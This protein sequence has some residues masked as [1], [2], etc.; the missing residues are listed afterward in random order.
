MKFDNFEVNISDENARLAA[1]SISWEGYIS[2]IKSKDPRKK[3]GFRMIP[4]IAIGNTNYNLLEKFQQLVPI[5]KLSNSGYRPNPKARDIWYWRLS[6]SFNKTIWFLKRIL[7]Y[8][9]SKQRQAE[10]LLEY[11]ISRC[12]VFGNKPYSER[13][14]QIREEILTLNRKGIP[15]NS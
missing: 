7:P 6:S 5:G 12:N 14:L 8:L 9:P 15:L 2:L 3:G 1:W 11:C 13:E 4:R 10:L